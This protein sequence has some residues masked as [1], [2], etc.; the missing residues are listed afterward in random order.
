MLSKDGKKF[1]TE[2]SAHLAQKY[3]QQLVFF[4]PDVPYQLLM[5]FFFEATENKP[6]AKEKFKR[7][8]V[9]N[10]IKLLQDVLTEVGG[11]NDAQV[12]D[13]TGQKRQGLPERTIIWAWNLAEEQ[14]PHDG[15]FAS[16]T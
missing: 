6:G 9:D 12:Q 4:K 10:R 7:I 16:L 5:R 15:S 14:P 1:K 13:V 11:F 8:D 2:T 3:P